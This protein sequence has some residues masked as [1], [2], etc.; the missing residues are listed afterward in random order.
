MKPW[1]EVFEDLKDKY[2]SSVEVVLDTRSNRLRN[3]HANDKRFEAED[4]V[5]LKDSPNLCDPNPSVGA[6]GTRGRSCSSLPSAENSCSVLCCG[7]G[8]V[9]R[10][11]KKVSACHC[12]LRGFGFKCETCTEQITESF[13]K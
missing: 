5:Y 11:R 8:R 2:D 3:F 10:V 4:L 12:T 7:R 6:L 1:R 13:C 9:L